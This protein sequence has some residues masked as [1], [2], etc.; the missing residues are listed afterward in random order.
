M[1]VIGP[2]L[3]LKPIALEK[4]EIH[5]DTN[6]AGRPAERD[7]FT[8][9]AVGDGRCPFRCQQGLYGP[10]D[11]LVFIDVENDGFQV[12]SFLAVPL[13]GSN[14]RCFRLPVGAPNVVN[15][16]D[17]VLHTKCNSRDRG[18]ATT[19]PIDERGSE[20][21]RQT[22]RHWRSGVRLL[23]R[24]TDPVILHPQASAAPPHSPQ[25]QRRRPLARPGTRAKVY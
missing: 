3:E 16:P 18:P 4:L 6:L 5:D 7:I 14:G 8:N 19:S 9:G 17:W 12:S 11:A 20:H 15:R 1:S 21:L 13:L 25:A 2:S 24:E 10:A 23:A 22:G